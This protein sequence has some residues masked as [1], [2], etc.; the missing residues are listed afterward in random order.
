[1]LVRQ[2]KT[3][4]EQSDDEFIDKA[5]ENRRKTKGQYLLKKRTWG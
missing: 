2:G 5:A 4:G 3:A 1:V